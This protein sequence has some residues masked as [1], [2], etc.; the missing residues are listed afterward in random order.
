[1]TTEGCDNARS[2]SAT[3]SFNSCAPNLEKRRNDCGLLPMWL[4]HV[5]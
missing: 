2:I 1:M 4:A 3:S 5:S